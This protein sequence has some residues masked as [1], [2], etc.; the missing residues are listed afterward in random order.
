MVEKAD[1]IWMDGKFVDWDKANVHVLSHALHYGS[2]VFE[3][4]KCYEAGKGSAIFRL[5]EHV[6]RLYDSAQ[7][8]GIKI[9]FSKEEFTK[10]IKDTVKLNKLKSCYIRPIV[11]LGYGPLGLNPV[12][13]PVNCAIAVWKW[14]AYLGEE[15]LAKGIRLKTSSFTRHH[16][17]VN[18][19][20]AKISGNYANSVMAKREAI[21]QGFDEAMMLDTQ[22]YVS[23]C[24]GENIFVIKN[25]VIKTT[26]LG[27]ILP[28]ITRASIIRIA[29]DLGYEIIEQPFAKD[30]VYVADEC[31]LTGTAAEVTPVREID[32]R[33]IGEGKPGRITKQLQEKFLNIVRGKE[34]KYEKWLT[35]I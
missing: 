3:G 14:G 11:F 28:G 13:S 5:K 31:F 6:D 10:A 17:N 20:K 26:P 7:I 8:F 32:N 27:S 30:E 21:L 22:G 34:K 16:V 19:T 2:A 23:E 9:P 33:T 29:K 15:G 25:G 24:T 4:I 18:M 12:Q 35:Y 1:K